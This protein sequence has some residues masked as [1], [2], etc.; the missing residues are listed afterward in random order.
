VSTTGKDQRELPRL[1]A[2]RAPDEGRVLLELAELQHARRR[3]LKVAGG[4]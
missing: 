4:E 2:A 1:K 3:G